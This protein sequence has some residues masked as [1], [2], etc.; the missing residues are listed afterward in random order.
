MKYDKYSGHFRSCPLTTT[1]A[2]LACYNRRAELQRLIDWAY[3][4]RLAGPRHFY[5]LSLQDEE[6]RLNRYALVYPTQVR[7]ARLL[8]S[9]RTTL[10]PAQ[11]FHRKGS[12]A[13][14]R[15]TK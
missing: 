11:R 5:K 6:I 13:G 2:I 4:K 14:Y 1:L 12:A 9:I 3:R 15:R 10:F 7:W 8:Y